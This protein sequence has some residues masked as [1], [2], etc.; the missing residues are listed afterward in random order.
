MASP[1]EAHNRNANDVRGAVYG[2]L[3]QVQDIHGGVTLNAAQAPP[4]VADVSLD[5]PRPAT[6]A[7][8]RAE[9][10]TE[11]Q[12]A[13]Q[14]GAPVPH[15]L[16]G[17]GGFGKT[18]VAATL[19]EHA[20]SEG[21]TVFWVRPDAIVPSMLEVAVELGGSRQEAEQ[22]KVAPRSATRWVWRHLD[23]APR[24]WLLVID[25]ADQPELLDPENR[26]GEQR[27]W[28]RASPGGFVLVTSRVDD[29]A[30]WAPAKVHRVEV[31]EDT[32]AAVA[33]TDHSGLA[34]LPGAA[35]LAERLG[36]V[37]LALTLAGRVLATHQVLFPDADA[38]LRHLGEDVARIDT[39]AAPL[40]TG[41]D[42][43]RRLLSE[44]WEL[45]LRL[46]TEREPTAGPLLR[47]LSVLGGNAVAVPL[48]RLPLSE[49]AGGALGSLDE[50]G[51]A[52]AINELVVHGLVTVGQRAGE[53]ALR[54]HPLVSESI[55]VNLGP[56]SLPLLE[57]AERLLRWR[58]DHDYVLEMGAYT[59]LHRVLSRIHDPG[60]P[61]SVRVNAQSQRSLMLLGHR[62]EAERN[63]RVIADQSRANLGGDHPESL[64]AQHTLADA[65][66]DLDR[67]E[68][69]EEIFRSVTRERESVLGT[70]HP[71]TLSS[72][73]QVALMRGLRGDLATAEEEFRSLWEEHVKLSREED[74]GALQALENLSFVL[75]YRGEHDAAE[76]GFRRVGQVRS[77]LLGRLHP[78]TVETGYNLARVA[79]ERG[80]YRTAAEGFARTMETREEI[81]GEDHPATSMTR[82]WYEK[83]GRL[84]EG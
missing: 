73:H 84:A 64:R 66:R 30:L 4:P 32:E 52:R 11:L 80:D 23:A 31:L 22:F 72:R 44:V 21:W 41:P 70:T 20:R 51:L 69:A 34:E 5:P 45:S 74:Q 57:T 81:L 35:D 28:M 71:E 27:G 53:T 33:L 12:S 19:A 55:R 77:R 46:V 60:H 15:V 76:E 63:L 16:T 62:E 49:L 65:L 75:M 8:G 14:R 2:Q 17:P 13:M 59:V 48:R 37:P 78:R 7:R 3:L 61:E 36:G 39:L 38:L 6:P 82:E 24:P 25:N 1:P 79:F 58:A 50:A 42:S 18:T 54:L 83:A 29:P 40:V 47:I 56:E 68:E 10:L 67:F 43:E 26:P 9:L